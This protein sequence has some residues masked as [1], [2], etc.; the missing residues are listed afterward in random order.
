MSTTKN[1]SFF[2]GVRFASHFCGKSLSLAYTG[3]TNG[4]HR[5]KQLTTWILFCAQKKLEKKQSTESI[6]VTPV[7]NVF[8]GKIPLKLD[9]VTVGY[10]S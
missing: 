10:I 7:K 8:L 6:Y 9:F 1:Y 4:R 3:F 5:K 2:I